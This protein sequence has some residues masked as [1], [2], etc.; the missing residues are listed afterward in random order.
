MRI[1]QFGRKDLGNCQR[2][3]TYCMATLLHM[4]QMWQRQWWAQKSWITILT[5]LTQP[6]VILI[7]LNQ[8]RCTQEDGNFKPMMNS[9]AMSKTDHAGRI[10]TCMLLPSVTHQDYRK[11]LCNRTIAWKGGRVW[12]FCH[13]HSFVKKSPTEPWITFV[14]WDLCRGWVCQCLGNSMK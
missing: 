5:F 10:K 11:N 7:C 3:S 14:C 1:K 4:W 6:Q 12:W 8:W 13:V 2:S 9:N